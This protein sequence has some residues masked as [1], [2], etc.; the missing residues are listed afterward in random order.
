MPYLQ[1][2]LCPRNAVCQLE[3]QG[4]GVNFACFHQWHPGGERRARRVL[5]RSS[6]PADVQRPYVSH[7]Q[8]KVI[9]HHIHRA[10]TSV[11]VTVQK[12][13]ILLLASMGACVALQF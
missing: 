5:Y 12:F 4:K 9:V 11:N 6:V 1:S 10:D 8:Q 7:G 13:H 3:S 2:E